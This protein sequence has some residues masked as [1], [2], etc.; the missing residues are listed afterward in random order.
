[1]NHAIR[2]QIDWLIY[3]SEHWVMTAAHC[4]EGGGLNYVVAGL[5]NESIWEEGQRRRAI[6]RILH[7][8]YNENVW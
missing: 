4:L 8:D 7:P 2:G 3:F 1:M 5:H 6:L